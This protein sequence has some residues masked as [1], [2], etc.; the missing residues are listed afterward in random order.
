MKPEHIHLIDPTVDCV[1]KRLLG[2]E[3]H[4]DLTL[5]FLNAVLER[6]GAAR[7]VE[8]IFLK[9]HLVKNHLEEKEPIVD[10]MVRDQR[11]DFYLIE[12][13]NQHERFLEQRAFY[14][15][16]KAIAGTLAEGKGYGE[17]KCVI[18]IWLLSECMF[19]PSVT[20]AAALRFRLHCPEEG[21]DF[22]PGSSI[23]VLQ[24]PNFREAAK[25]N[26]EKAMWLRFFREAKHADPNQ[27]PSWLQ[28][29]TLKEALKVL[30]EFANDQEAYFYYM[31]RDKAR[32]AELTRTNLY[33]T[34]AK[35]LFETE[36]K[37]SNTEAKLSNTEAKLSNTEA[38][39]T[40]TKARLSNT[41][42]MLHE[43][44]KRMSVLEQSQGGSTHA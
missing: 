18:S 22:W 14:G 31:R 2:S 19:K 21:L 43:L 20:R 30:Q 9:T 4:K 37:L 25:M 11:G 42:A 27:P 33:E 17:L 38:E 24:L 32:L 6:E 26:P 39:L 8:V 35:Q 16:A 28:H 40:D 15:W 13:Q 5:S 29:P 23:I 12:I 3:Q 41:E 1:V 10:I 7:L 44:A 36:A 34:T